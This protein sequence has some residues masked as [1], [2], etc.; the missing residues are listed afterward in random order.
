MHIAA[1]DYFT[2][3]LGHGY[4]M[5]INYLGSVKETKQLFLAQD[6]FRLRT[7]CPDVVPVSCPSVVSRKSQ[8]R[9]SASGGL[10]Y[11]PS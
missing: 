8:A 6:D 1:D 3:M 5:K 9:H 4:A 10:I 2:D 11:T 7:L